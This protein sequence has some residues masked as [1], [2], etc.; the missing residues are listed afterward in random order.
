MGLEH[1]DTQTRHLFARMHHVAQRL[2]EIDL[3]DNQ[4][5]G[6]GRP[7]RFQ[8]RASPGM[9]FSI[10]FQVPGNIRADPTYR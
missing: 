8:L 3:R 6:Q 7:Q 5:I 9:V 4:I 2:S 1:R 10:S